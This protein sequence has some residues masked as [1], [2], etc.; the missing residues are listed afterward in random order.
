MNR[1]FRYLMNGLL[2][3]AAAR[4]PACGGG[5]DGAGKNPGRRVQRLAFPRWWWQLRCSRGD[6]CVR[7]PTFFSEI[8]EIYIVEDL[9][10]SP[11][12][13]QEEEEEAQE[14]KKRAGEGGDDGGDS[15]LAS[16][17]PDYL[18]TCGWEIR[19]EGRSVVVAEPGSSAGA[20]IRDLFDAPL[21]QLD[22]SIEES[23]RGD[24]FVLQAP[25][26]AYC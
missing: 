18:A 11:V 10:L 4:R 19:R 12:A 14:K 22:L 16:L 24:S 7:P 2:R 9:A 15:S 1:D 25:D 20:R 5:G 21:G 3:E 26:T 13:E 6:M 23:L 8:R 17:V